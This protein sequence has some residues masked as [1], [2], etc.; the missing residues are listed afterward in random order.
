MNQ[1]SSVAFG[2]DINVFAGY[3]Q[4]AGDRLGSIS[5]VFENTG[6]NAATIRLGYHD[7][8]TSPSGYSIIDSFDT[9][10]NTQG[11]KVAAGGQVTKSYNLISKTIGF[12]GSGNTTVNIS[13]V[14]ANKA[15]LR[16]AQI[17]IKAVGRKNWS[18][19]DGMDFTTTNKKWGT[20][21]APST[22]SN[23]NAGSGNI[24]PTGVVKY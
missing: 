2:S 3:A 24:D 14:I 22:S 17:D 12:F 19:E 6:P 23:I 4:T 10:A 1:L 8:T 21:S 18:V 11:F 7:G 16:G 20:V 9:T 5:F 15:N 13:T